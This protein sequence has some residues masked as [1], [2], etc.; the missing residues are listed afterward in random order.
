MQVCESVHLWE[1]EDLSLGHGEAAAMEIDNVVPQS[2]EQPSF[3]VEDL[4]S[5]EL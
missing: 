2:I 5:L 4:L 3:T 1:K